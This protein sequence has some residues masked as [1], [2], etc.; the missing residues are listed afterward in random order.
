ML[1]FVKLYIFYMFILVIIWRL[2][3]DVQIIILKYYLTP[4]IS[5]YDRN[6]EYKYFIYKILYFYIVMFTRLDW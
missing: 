1:I 3:V 2:D 4:K 6:I 5:K